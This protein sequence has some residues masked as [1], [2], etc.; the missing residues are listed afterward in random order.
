VL[1]ISS[2]NWW[3]LVVAFVAGAVGGLAAALILLDPTES[4][5]PPPNGAAAAGVVA[6]RTAVGA[7]AAVAFLF[8]FPTEQQTTV[9]AAGRAATTITVYPFLKVVALA[10]VVGTG[11]SAFLSSMRNQA[12][13]FVTTSKAN[14]TT[15][16]VRA[17]S[18]TALSLLPR[19]ASDA[20][21]D[22]ATQPVQATKATG[23]EQIRQAADGLPPRVEAPGVDTEG[24]VRAA[25]AHAIGTTPGEVASA[26]VGAGIAALGDVA[27]TIPGAV[28]ARVS[29][30]MHEEVASIIRRINAI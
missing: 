28:E 5:T 30:T 9:L 11:G 1:Q 2:S 7:V 26:D 16:T 13:S 6:I 18:I 29:S 17:T 19:I 22:G 3:V 24:Q 25:V 12:A 8:F 4:P 15:A 10:I 20:A 21:K 14:Q 23:A 27:D